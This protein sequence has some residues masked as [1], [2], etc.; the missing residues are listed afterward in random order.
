MISHS[1]QRF[2]YHQVRQH[3]KHRRRANS[4][5]MSVQDIRTPFGSP[6]EPIALAYEEDLGA[7]T[8]FSPTNS[9]DGA[10]LATWISEDNRDQETVRAVKANLPASSYLYYGHAFDVTLLLETTLLQHGMT[11]EF[12]Q[13]KER[14]RS[15]TVAT[16]RQCQA[17]RDAEPNELHGPAGAEIKI[18][19]A[20]PP[21]PSILAQSSRRTTFPERGAWRDHL[22]HVMHHFSL[23]ALF[24][25]VQRTSHPLMMDMASSPSFLPCAFPPCR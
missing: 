2:L 8:S 13:P 16:V 11:G 12:K 3:E 20:V 10:S 15:C 24:G 7:P 14:E 5:I 23:D 4:W 17:R 9:M 22:G 1:C 19:P 18:A 25:A 21:H 6:G